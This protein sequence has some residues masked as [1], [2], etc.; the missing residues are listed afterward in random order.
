M[1]EHS[2]RRSSTTFSIIV[3]TS[4]PGSL[5]ALFQEMRS[6]LRFNGGTVIHHLV[7]EATQR[8]DF[9]HDHLKGLL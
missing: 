8:L 1:A 4:L 7:V 9:L 5:K 6:N 3:D 2:W